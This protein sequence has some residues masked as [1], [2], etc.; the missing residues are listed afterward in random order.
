[1]FGRIAPRYDLA[2]HVLSGNIDR[3][4]R[5]HTVRRVREVLERPGARVLDVCCGTGDLLLALEKRARSG[6]IGSDFCHPMLVSARE[7]A[8]LRR[9]RAEV[10]ESDAMNL[11]LRDESLDLVTVAFGFRNLTNYQAGLEEMLRVLKPG[12]MAAILEFSQPKNRAFAALYNFYS[13]RVL[14]V[15]GGMLTGSPDAYTYLPESVRKFPA[16]EALAEAMRRAGFSE[17]RYDLLT[18]GAVALHMGRKS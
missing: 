7:K 8:V 1:M 14:P 3:W 16:A 15:I 13:R 2:N 5:A 17:V 6:V 12:G 9:A 11:P 4:W 10:F 18:G